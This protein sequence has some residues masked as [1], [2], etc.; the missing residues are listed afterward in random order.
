MKELMKIF[1]DKNI[2]KVCLC[3]GCHDVRGYWHANPNGNGIWM[4]IA[5]RD[6][7]CERCGCFEQSMLPRNNGGI[8]IEREW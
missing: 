5:D 4:Q 2:T 3:Y 1:K 8:A 7:K 6:T